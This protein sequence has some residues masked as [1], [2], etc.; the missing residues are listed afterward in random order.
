MPVCPGQRKHG[1]AAWADYDNDGD[2]DVYVTGGG[3]DVA[4]NALYRNNGDG[5]F[6]DVAGAAGVDDITAG[7]GAAWADYDNDGDLDLFVANR[8]Q[9]DSARQ[10]ADRLY[11]NEGNGTFT[12]VARSAGVAGRNSRRSFMG[13]WLDYDMDGFQDLY[14]AVDFGNDVLYRNDR[15]GTFTNISRTA[16]ISGPQH[17]MGVAVGD[18][19]ADGCPDVFSTN[20]TS[21]DDDEHGPSALYMNNCDGT[22]A[23]GRASIGILDRKVIEWGPN[24]VDW[25]N[26]ADLDLAVTA[27]GLLTDG[28]PNIL[29]ENRCGDTG[30]RLHDVTDQSGVA[31][32]QGGLGSAWAD[33]D[34]DGD[35]DWFV[36]N[37]KSGPSSLY[38]N[39]STSG[40]FLKIRLTGVE[41]NRR[42]VGAAIEVT[43]GGRT[44]Y[45]TIRAGTGYAS[46]EEQEAFFGL[47]P[48]KQA[49]R[50]RVVWPSGLVSE[51]ENI[52]ANQT[53]EIVE[54]SAG[55]SGNAAVPQPD[56]AAL[57]LGPALFPAN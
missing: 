40:T 39:N 37:Y 52:R 15:D 6:A 35:L 36:A 43:A 25:D 49:D 12:N 20:N 4:P 18:L 57:P 10:I 5:T 7:T 30:C 45:G 53:L 31:N 13:V 9:T 47:G 29:Y 55:P 44:Q 32:R 51:L 1:T 27:G 23:D 22:F 19:N 24:F 38:R 3:L 16:G 17:G 8:W 41:S 28:E 26:D 46:G 11:R 54:S 2:L 34:N 56:A 48:F 33:I 14:L 21:E 42:G 50:V